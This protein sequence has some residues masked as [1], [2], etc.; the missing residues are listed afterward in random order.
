MAH[1]PVPGSAVSASIA[2]SSTTIPKT[3]LAIARSRPVSLALVSVLGVAL[4][5]RLGVVLTQGYV[6]FA[7]ETFQ[8]L[9]QGHR[10][11]FG[12]GV[13]PWEFQ[14]GIRSWLLPG[15]VAGV[16]R[17]AAWIWDD[18]RLYL[19]LARLSCVLL[20]LTVVV[21]G[22]RMALR[23]DGLAAAIL[24]GGF[25][26]LWFDL[27]YFAPTV[28]TEVMAAHLAILAIGLGDEAFDDARAAPRRWF[29]AGVCCGLVVCLRFQYGPAL[30]V[31]ILWQNR[32]SWARWRPMLAGGVL[33]FLLGAG[34]LDWVTW[35]SPFQSIWLNI[36]RN[37]ADGVS[38]AM[39][40]D[41]PAFFLAYL[42]VALWPAPVL[43]FL[44]AVGAVRA[45]ALA[46]AAFVTL[47]MHSLVP[48]KEVRFIY[49]TLAAMPILAGLGAASLL[50]A[51]AE[52]FG[53]PLRGVGVVGLLGLAAMLSWHNATGPGLAGRWSFNR[54]TIGLFLAANQR[55]DLCGLGVRDMR[56]IDSGGYAYLHRDVPMLFADFEPEI[57]LDG[58]RVPLRFAVTRHGTA[59]P[60]APGT[61]FGA[62][63]GRYNYLIAAGGTTPAG[64]VPIDCATNAARRDLP[65]LCLFRRDGGCT[66]R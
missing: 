18:P 16:M 12:T 22:F 66:G 37:G 60:Q 24:T 52:R 56:V 5:V 1:L 46:L 47:A 17:A 23:R 40:T 10:L 51:P 32:L 55:P 54:A 13:L 7:D 21:V 4:A 53:G 36:L 27:A 25:C 2:T 20:S 62:A 19:F 3:T 26:A 41:G 15:A 28:M 63:A 64:F 44:V 39:G 58:A 34:V 43:L 57:R 48:H 61:T 59:V 30:A 33:T 9:E 35:G 45:P 14:D 38:A 8:Y 42:D 50:R 29:L 6:V 65:P 11:A 31:A 49:L